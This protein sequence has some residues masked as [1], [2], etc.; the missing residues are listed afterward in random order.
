M[1]RIKQYFFLFLVSVK[2]LFWVVCLTVYAFK[3]IH[4]APTQAP[5][6][7]IEYDHIMLNDTLQGKEFN[8]SATIDFY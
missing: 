4:A 5:S 6:H 3:P 1:Y 8:T 7:S 2:V